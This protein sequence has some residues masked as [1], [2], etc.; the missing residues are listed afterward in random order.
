[1]AQAR[2]NEA[3]L[4]RTLGNSRRPDE[5]MLEALGVKSAA[6]PAIGGCERS[7][8]VPETAQPAMAERTRGQASALPALASQFW[9]F[10]IVPA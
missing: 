3:I 7:V 1:M 9:E 10:F 8:Y 2:R 4:L 5:P 6:A